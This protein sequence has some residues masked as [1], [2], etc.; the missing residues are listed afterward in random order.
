MKN[1]VSFARPGLFAAAAAACAVAI[2]LGPLAPA[3]PETVGAGQG[4]AY[5]D[6]ARILPQRVLEPDLIA[7]CSVHAFT[8]A[9]AAA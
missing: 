7:L 4:A 8:D 3:T 1:S 6:C 2:A 9:Q 5:L